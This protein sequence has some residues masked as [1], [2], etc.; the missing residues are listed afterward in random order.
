MSL[1]DFHEKYAPGGIA[2][3]LNK[4]DREKKER[5]RLA[6]E[7]AGLKKRNEIIARKT[8]AGLSS[9]LFQLSTQP[10]KEISSADKGAAI[11]KNALYAADPKLRRAIKRRDIFAYNDA[12]MNLRTMIA[13]T[14]GGPKLAKEMADP[15]EIRRQARLKRR[16]MG[17]REQT[18]GLSY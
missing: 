14:T 13:R 9:S 7:A 1:R 5:E 3:N 16:P 15:E 12:L 17:S 8:P 6:L 11:R 10:G 4:R 2:A 18:L